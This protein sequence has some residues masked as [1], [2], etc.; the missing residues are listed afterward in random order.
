[1]FVASNEQ[2][3]PVLGGVGPGVVLKRCNIL[4]KADRMA[5]SSLAMARQQSK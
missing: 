4:F 2:G 1:M 5:N 3:M